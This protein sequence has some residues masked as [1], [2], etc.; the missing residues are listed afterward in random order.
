MV[1]HKLL[2][3]IPAMILI[4]ILF[5]MAPLSLANKCNF[6]IHKG[7]TVRTGTAYPIRAAIV[8]QDDTDDI[9]LA[10]A[11]GEKPIKVALNSPI[12]NSILPIFNLSSESMALRC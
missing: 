12:I 3:L 6:V 10:P 2:L 11:P 8:S 1:R 9:S 4:P 5:V 7:H